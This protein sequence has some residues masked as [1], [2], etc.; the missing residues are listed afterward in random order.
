[1]DGRLAVSVVPAADLSAFAI[2]LLASFR[3]DALVTVRPAAERFF[4]RAG[5][6]I[7]PFAPPFRT[8][9]FLATA[10]LPAPFL[11]AALLATSFLPKLLLAARF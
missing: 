3:V 1:V 5:L 4:A 7:D 11:A 2:F 10:T 8:V 6:P 9:V